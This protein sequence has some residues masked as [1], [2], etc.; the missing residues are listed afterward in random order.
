[1]LFRSTAALAGV[2]ALVLSDGQPAPTRIGSAI[3][4]TES[5]IANTAPEA[6][7]SITPSL[8]DL[9]VSVR[10]SGEHRPAFRGLFGKDASPV[11]VTAVA[12]YVAP[13]RPA[14][15]LG[16]DADPVGAVG[17]SKAGGSSPGRFG[18]DRTRRPEAE[19][20]PQFARRGQP[21]TI[22]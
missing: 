15:P 3:A 20:R 8:A 6:P 21:A 12:R 14:E 1:V 13:S 5:L 17:E 18:L 22:R 4:T 19:A 2:D 16:H 7:R 10:L 9:T 11:A